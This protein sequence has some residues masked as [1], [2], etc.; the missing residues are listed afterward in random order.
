M[1]SLTKF[2]T[3]EEAGVSF[4]TIQSSRPEGGECLNESDSA[5]LAKELINLETR[6]VILGLG[7]GSMPDDEWAEFEPRLPVAKN[8]NRNLLFDSDCFYR[9]PSAP[10]DCEGEACRI[11]EE[12]EGYPTALDKCEWMALSIIDAQDCLPAGEADCGK[13][14]PGVISITNVTR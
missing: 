6:T 3:S 1:Q 11:M 10:V 2:P 12:F 13:P 14:E 8:I 5:G 7:E 4:Q 9:S